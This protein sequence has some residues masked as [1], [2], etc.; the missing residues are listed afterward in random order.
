MYPRSALAGLLGSDGIDRR[1]H[2]RDAV[3]R[4]T[5][6]L[7]MFAHHLFIGRDVDPYLVARSRSSAMSSTSTF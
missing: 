6:L 5:A 7:R 4:K 3:G 1:T 2:L